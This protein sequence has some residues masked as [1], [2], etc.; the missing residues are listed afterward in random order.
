MI[1][2]LFSRQINSILGAAALVAVS[3]FISRLLGVIRDRI[4]AGQFGASET[5]D[6][7]YAAFR[8]PDLLFNLLIL[9][10]LSAGFIPVFTALIKDR[11]PN[12]TFS[13]FRSLNKDAWLLV[14]Q[15]L[16][17]LILVLVF[18]SVLGIIFAPALMVIVAP[19]FK[20]EARELTVVLTRIMFLSPLFLGI[21]SVL[22]GV[23]Q[24][25][26]RFLAYS[27]APIMYNL[28]II[29]GA[30]YLV[31]RFGIYGLA[32]GVI[33]GAILH[34]LIQIPSIV[35][36]GFTYSWKIHWRDS[37]L[38][39]IGLMMLPRT[40]SL[41]VTQI[42]LVVITA[43][44]SGLAVGSLTVFN[45]ANNLQYF[46]IGIFGLSFA[47]A[48]FP[49]LSA[50][51]FDKEKLVFNFSKTL[52]QIFFFIIPASVFL[53]ILR[54][55]IIRVILGTGNFDWQDTIM[56]MDT[57][58][59]FSLSLFAQA[60]I[61][62]L[63]RMFYA[64]HNSA[65]PFY[66]ALFSVVLNIGLSFWLSKLMGV[67]GLALA[68][69]ISAILNFILLW[70]FLHSEIGF[71]DQKNILLSVFR[72]SLAALIAGLAAQ[73]LKLIIWLFIDMTKFWGVLIQGLGAG[74]GGILIYLVL[75]FILK[76]PELDNFSSYFKKRLPWKKIK[77]DDQSEARGI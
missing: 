4:L 35:S 63:A 58:G 72:F 33:I 28:G 20:G 31:P 48:A 38:R 27:L 9:G 1:K 69:S 60:S 14:S 70:F 10:A 76:S 52:R 34:M 7:Y 73:G 43:I 66:I 41:G 64:R 51:A 21:S 36:L 57:L 49:T 24:S 29:F 54:A 13:L 12:Q 59:L 16:N 53:I 5:L 23:L 62:L 46:P 39:K 11:E 50:V 22:G 40:L 45:L 19:G 25:F 32:W 37:N 65:T 17:V 18:F 26:K 42:N 56:T 68:F 55:Q 30:L 47:V 77:I 61:P 3:S 8:I 67:P 15:V 74:L 71:L 75:C 44:A 2:R 6:I